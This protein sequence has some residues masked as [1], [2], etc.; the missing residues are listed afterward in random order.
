M[1]GLLFIC[2]AGYV[3]YLANPNQIVMLQ[4]LS[5]KKAWVSAL[6]LLISG[7]AILAATQ[8]IVVTLLMSVLAFSMSLI[9]APLLSTA[10][11]KQFHLKRPSVQPLRESLNRK[12][13]HAG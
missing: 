10:L 8:P 12:T 13:P 3:T 6:S 7:I 2:L 4:P 1:S 5:G 9:I 11:Q